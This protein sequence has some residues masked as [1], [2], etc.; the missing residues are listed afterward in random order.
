MQRGTPAV[1]ILAAAQTTAMAP[2]PLRAASKR[3]VAEL[4]EAARV[5]FLTSAAQLLSASLPTLSTHLGQCALRVRAHTAFGACPL[6]SL[7][8]IFWVI[9]TFYQRKK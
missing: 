5:N 1:V 8:G 7:V 9:L 3:T 2:T 4:P 6:R